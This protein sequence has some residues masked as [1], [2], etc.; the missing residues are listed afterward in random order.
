MVRLRRLNAGQRLDGA[1][2]VA[3]ILVV[4]VRQAGA[5]DVQPLVPAVDDGDA[6]GVLVGVGL[7]HHPVDDTE[8]RGVDADSE[9]KAR[10]GD[11]GEP[12]T[13]GQRAPGIAH[14]L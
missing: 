12:A 11:G 4:R 13:L 14:I 1:G 3:Q 6:V 7:E 10:D 9:G 8:D 2:L 5:V